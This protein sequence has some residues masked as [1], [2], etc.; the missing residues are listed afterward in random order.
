M[1]Q[2][3]W[4]RMLLLCLAR[5]STLQ[6]CRLAVLGLSCYVNGFHSGSIYAVGIMAF[7]IMQVKPAH[8]RRHLTQAKSQPWC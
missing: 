1:A 4:S 3:L 6:S 2:G 8:A 5:P 7:D